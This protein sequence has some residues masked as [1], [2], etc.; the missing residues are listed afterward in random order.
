MV[1]A[2]MQKVRHGGKPHR[3]GGEEFCLLFKSSDAEKV[4]NGLE[5]LREDIAAYAMVLRDG[6]ARPAKT[7]DGKGKRGASKTKNQ[8]NVTVSIGAADSQSVSGSFDEHMKAADQALYKAKSGGRNRLV[9]AAAGA[10]RSP[11]AKSA[12]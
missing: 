9:F 4:A 10:T 1:A 12:L 3:Y 6:K 5:T 7:E 11:W 8:L 2:R